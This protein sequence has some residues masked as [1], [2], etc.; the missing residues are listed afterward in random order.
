MTPTDLQGE[1]KQALFVVLNQ[2]LIGYVCPSD[3]RNLYL[4]HKKIKDLGDVVVR[5]KGDHGDFARYY[6]VDEI[7]LG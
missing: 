6:A 7:R 3:K 1:R 5:Q 2:I 4:R